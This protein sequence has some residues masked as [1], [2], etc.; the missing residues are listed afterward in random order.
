MFQR[1]VYDSTDYK[2]LKIAQLKNGCEQKSQNFPKFQLFCR[3]VWE[4]I[5]SMKCIFTFCNLRY[6]LRRAKD[7]FVISE[8]KELKA[9]ATNQNRQSG[10]PYA[11]GPLLLP[12]KVLQITFSKSSACSG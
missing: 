12:L 3:R 2:A 5:A 6:Q 1:V 11:E 4:F 9:E 10:P 8:C 7:V